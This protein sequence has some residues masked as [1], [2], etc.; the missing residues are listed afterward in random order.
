MPLKSLHPD[1]CPGEGAGGE[2]TC[3]DSFYY[4][5]HCVLTVLTAW[6]LFLV[7]DFL[8]DVPL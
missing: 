7:F 8:Q 2:A 4:L 5:F 1:S 6:K 3:H